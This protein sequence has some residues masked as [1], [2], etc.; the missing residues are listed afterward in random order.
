M[1]CNLPIVATDVGDVREVVG[2]TSGCYVCRPDVVEFVQRLGVILAHRER[3]QGRAQVQHLGGPA[4]ARRIIEVY[5][6]VLK[7]RE[8]RLK[9]RTHSN[10]L[11]MRKD[12]P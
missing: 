11:I 1:A 7:K 10:A 8:R 2:S 12:V 5:E 4:V 3:T 9:D 6:Q